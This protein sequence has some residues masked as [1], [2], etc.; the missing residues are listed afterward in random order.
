VKKA[1]RWR[2]LGIGL[3][4]L[5]PSILGFLCFT[6]IP[7]VLSLML[8]FSNWDL[9]F[10]NRFHH[11]S[12]QFVGL[13]N[14]HRLL[15]R[16]D[17][18]RFLGNTFVF[19]L[20]IPI[21]IFGSLILAMM[22]SSNLAAGSRRGLFILVLIVLGVAA[23]EFSFILATGG[24]R[25]S[26][27][28]LLTITILATIIAG[29]VG[30]SVIYRTLLYLPS[31]TSGVAI[32]LLWK[33]LYSPHTGPINHAL[34]PLLNLV[35]TASQAMPLWVHSSLLIACEVGVGGCLIWGLLKLVRLW[36][37]SEISTRSLSIC[38]FLT[39]T[40]VMVSFKTEAFPLWVSIIFAAAGVTALIWKSSKQSAD[41]DSSTPLRTELGP[42]IRITMS[43]MLCGFMLLLVHAISYRLHQNGASP[44][45]PPNWLTDY[46][47]AKP[48]MVIIGIWA[49]LGS[50]NM[51]LYLAG[52]SN[53]PAELYEA[54]ELDGAGARQKFWCVTWPHLAPTTFFIV[55]MSII[56]GLQGGFEMARSMT[57]GGP[58]GSTT[59][60]AY[61]IYTEGF[62]TGRMG[63]SCAISWLLFLM[64]ALITAF[65]WKFGKQYVGD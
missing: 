27:A 45:Q 8:A 31:F 56:A 54:A 42:A 59:S 51:L 11:R 30:G 6:L 26:V 10:H 40:P 2:Q 20:G 48:A 5:S 1:T 22:L 34:A 3:A 49:A 57:N 18:W 24:Q 38:S 52:L 60:L 44:L 65:N 43:A 35:S 61:Y 37:E 58:A 47:W 13:E 19:M 50:N 16:P 41:R 7:L 15:V 28:A 63:Y 46:Q 36:L 9:R 33:K 29:F 14:F 39:F 12:L 4:F 53:I 64:I 17:F 62:E 25:S 55:V 21:S 23:A 32:F